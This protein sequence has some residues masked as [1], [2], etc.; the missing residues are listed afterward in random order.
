MLKV[1]QSRSQDCDR[2]DSLDL[3]RR[4]TSG[5]CRSRFGIQRFGPK[6]PLL[7]QGDVPTHLFEILEGTVIRVFTFPDGRRQIIE[8]ITKGMMIG[9][10]VEERNGASAIA[11]TDV[12]ARRFDRESFLAVESLQTIMTGQLEQQLRRSHDIVTM[13]GKKTVAER[14]ATF[15]FRIAESEGALSSGRAAQISIQLPI[16][17]TDLADY[18]CL[19]LETVT[20][21]F[22]RLE[23]AGIIR[24]HNRSTVILL[25]V[26]RLRGIAQGLE[27]LDMLVHGRART[28]RFVRLW[29]DQP[30]RDA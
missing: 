26:S 22:A 13:L 24:R 17:R 11:V 27:G 20:R 14:I 29:R 2:F 21:A 23:K 28:N 6:Q 15:L 3:V 18:L 12:R 9:L 7:R 8:L 30:A 16:S 25:D 4:E 5:E 10:P 19:R 1:E